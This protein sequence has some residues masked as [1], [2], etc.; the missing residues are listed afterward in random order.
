MVHTNSRYDF[1]DRLREAIRQAGEDGHG[2]GARLARTTHVTPK[3]AS[4]WLNGEARPNH[5]KLLVLCKWLKVR[6]EWL[7]YGRG[8]MRP[9]EAGTS[10]YDRSREEEQ[11]AKDLAPLASPRSQQSLERIARAASEGRLTE[12][13]L[14]MLEQIAQRIAATP[15][16]NQ[17]KQNKRHERLKETLGKHDPP[18]DT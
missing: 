3:A 12:Q 5:D 6:E 14:L 10:S 7:E 18:A 15:T 13:D 9:G 11:R 17:P 1:S 16:A 8:P 4:K 2:M